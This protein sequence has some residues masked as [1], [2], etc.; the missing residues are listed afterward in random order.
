MT[1]TNKYAADDR[2]YT[3]PEACQRI[4]LRTTALYAQIRKGKL[5]ARKLGRRTY[6]FESDVQAF[7][8]NTPT[9]TVDAKH[10]QARAA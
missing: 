9:A 6:I 2:R 8:A 1:A 3:V 5:V 7:L 4:G 10:Q